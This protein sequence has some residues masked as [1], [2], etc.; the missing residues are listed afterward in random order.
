MIVS[1]CN[2]K[3]PTGV[4]DQKNDFDCVVYCMQCMHQLVSN[5]CMS[6]LEMGTKPVHDNYKLGSARSYLLEISHNTTDNKESTTLLTSI[7][8][9]HYFTVNSF[10]IFSIT[11]L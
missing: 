9:S 6:I 2:R 11:E 5:E 10:A 3:T 8:N 4:F 7:D 1:K